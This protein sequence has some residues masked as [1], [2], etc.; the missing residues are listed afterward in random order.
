MLAELGPRPALGKA[1]NRKGLISG[2]H[3]HTPS[4]SS[5]VRAVTA[6]E[7]WDRSAWK[8]FQV[9]GI[10]PWITLSQKGH[11]IVL[12]LLLSFLGPLVSFP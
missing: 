12:S 10:L 4:P 7:T 11:N 6:G 9:K 2:S 5:V 8:N 1:G 3:I